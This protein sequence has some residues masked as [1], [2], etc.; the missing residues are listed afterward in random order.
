L[1]TSQKEKTDKKITKIIVNTDC[2]NVIHLINGDK[3]L[4]KRYNLGG[5][6]DHLVLKLNLLK[7]EYK[8]G[9]TLTEFRHVKSHND[10]STKKGWVNEWCDVEAKKHIKD[11]I[12]KNNWK[13]KKVK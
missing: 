6:G 9:Q 13:F 2:L 8:H 10:T 4:I 11:Y 3:Q 7:T 12:D 5:W 1:K